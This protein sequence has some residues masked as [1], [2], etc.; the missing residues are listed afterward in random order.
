M[1]RFIFVTKRN[2]NKNILFSKY[3]NNEIAVKNSTWYAPDF[4]F[5]V[6]SWS[7][8]FKVFQYH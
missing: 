5:Y 7:S 8:P 3:N 4:L 6:F 2:L 1:F